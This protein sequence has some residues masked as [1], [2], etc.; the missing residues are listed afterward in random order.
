MIVPALPP[1]LI[2]PC[3]SHQMLIGG[4]KV[5]LPL[6]DVPVLSS[7]VPETLLPATMNVATPNEL[8]TFASAGSRFRRRRS[9]V[10]LGWLWF[11]AQR[12]QTQPGCRFPERTLVSAYEIEDRVSPSAASQRHAATRRD[13][14]CCGVGLVHL[15]GCA[16]PRIIDRE[17]E[18]PELGMVIIPPVPWAQDWVS[19]RTQGRCCC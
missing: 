7:L 17:R 9:S 5:W 3:R 15:K 8:E 2:V 16:V 19:P 12:S 11:A 14:N 18:I 1:V 6:S 13:A 4:V 10:D